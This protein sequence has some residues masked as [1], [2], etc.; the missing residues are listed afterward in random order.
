M[1]DFLKTK[2]N[3]ETF[4]VEVRTFELKDFVEDFLV[5]K[6]D[7][8]ILFEDSKLSKENH[9]DNFYFLH[10]N[11]VKYSEI[12]TALLSINKQII[13]EIIK[14]QN[15]QA[16]GKYFCRCCG[17]NTLSEFPNGTYEICEIC[18]WEDDTYQTENPNEEGGP[19]RVSLTQGRIN[20]EK[21]GACE[22][23]M[24]KNVRKP[25][26]KDIKKMIYKVYKP[27]CS[28]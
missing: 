17:F 3:D 27:N 8:E 9:F 23:D 5:E 16:D 7:F 20:F 6:F 4:V 1:N 28:K 26:E 19:N 15:Y 2:L 10:F 12:E 21:F 11:K 25:T 22:L 14:D 13:Q 24:K 18:F